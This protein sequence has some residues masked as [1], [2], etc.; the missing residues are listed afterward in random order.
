MTSEQKRRVVQPGDIVTVHYVGKLDDG[1]VFDSS[2][3]TGEPFSFRAGVGEVIEGFD[4]AVLGLSVGEKKT[5][6]LEPEEAYG[7]RDE[8]LIIQVPAQ[9]APE[10]L[11]VGDRVRLGQTPAT[12]VGVTEEVITLDANHPLAGEALTFEVELI[13]IESPED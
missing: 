7:E 4:K 11:E 10:G 1:E 9:G 12:V 6:R 3:E 13:S 2:R 5:F 8:D